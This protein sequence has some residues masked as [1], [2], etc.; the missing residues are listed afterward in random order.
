LVARTG[1]AAV[2]LNGGETEAVGALVGGSNGGSWSGKGR[3]SKTKLVAVVGGSYEGSCSGKGDQVKQPWERKLVARTEALGTVGTSLGAIFGG[4]NGGSS[5][6]LERRQNSA[7]W[8]SS[9]QVD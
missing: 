5:W 8:R 2:G 1:A 4:S 6:W 7:S 3:P 9:W